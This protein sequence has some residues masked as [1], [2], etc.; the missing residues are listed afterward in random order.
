MADIAKNIKEFLDELA[1]DPMEERVV[2]YVIREVHSG[3]RLVEVMDDPF[4]KNRL[5][6]EKRAS[7]LENPEIVE[8]VEAE[9]KATFA[10]HELD[11]NN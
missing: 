10:G 2:E 3:R 5:N 6:D 7:V 11:F 1:A 8:A 4:V 9:I